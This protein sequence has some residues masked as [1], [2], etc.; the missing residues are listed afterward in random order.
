VQNL[1]E[2]ASGGLGVS[3]G[4][5]EPLIELVVT[6]PLLMTKGQPLVKD[7]DCLR[8]R[9]D[10][11]THKSLTCRACVFLCSLCPRC[12]YVQHLRHAKHELP[13]SRHMPT[14]NF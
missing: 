4:A 9:F 14:S 3:G 13:K 8:V 10:C 1:L 6:E 7:W 12:R 2:E 11:N 5:G